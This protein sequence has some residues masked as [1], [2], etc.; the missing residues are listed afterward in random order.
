[1]F[2]F[3]FSKNNVIVLLIVFTESI[4]KSMCFSVNLVLVLQ[5]GLGIQC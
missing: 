1:M 2:C 5:V 3:G 4:A